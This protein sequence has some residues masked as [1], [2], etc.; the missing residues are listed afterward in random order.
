MSKK[1]YTK[2]SNNSN[3]PILDRIDET[4]DNI[5]PVKEVDGV[6]TTHI[7]EPIQEAENITPV[8]EV[9]GVVVKCTRLN[10]RKEPTPKADILCTVDANCEVVIDEANSTEDFYKVYTAAGIEGYCVKYFISIVP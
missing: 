3:K 8:R 2:F 5:D 7:K 1:D 4:V 9:K 10:V 6:I